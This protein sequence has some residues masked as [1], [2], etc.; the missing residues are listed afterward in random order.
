MKRI[1]LGICLAALL[2]LG[3]ADQTENSTRGP[4]QLT[5][6]QVFLPIT[7]FTVVYD[8]PSCP[9]GYDALLDNL[10]SGA[11]G[12]LVTLCYETGDIGKHPIDDITFTVDDEACPQ[13][14]ETVREFNSVEPADLNYG[15]FKKW[16]FGWFTTTKSVRMCYRRSGGETSNPIYHL[17]ILNK[18][19]PP[20]LYDVRPQ[21]LNS[22]LGEETLYV[23][24]SR[25]SSMLAA[26]ISLAGK[27]NEP[28][29][30]LAWSSA[31]ED[32][33]T[34]VIT[35]YLSF[36]CETNGEDFDFGLEMCSIA[37]FPYV[38]NE[39]QSNRLCALAMT[40][41]REYWSGN[42]TVK[43]VT[44]YIEVNATATN[45]APNKD[46]NI[47]ATTDPCGY[48]L[49]INA[50][51]DFGILNSE[52]TLFYQAGVFQDTEVHIDDESGEEAIENFK[53]VAAHEI[54]HS[55]LTKYKGL[56]YSASHKGTSSPSPLELFCES[57]VYELPECPEAPEPVDIM[58]YYNDTYT[59][60][61]DPGES[62]CQNGVCCD[63]ARI[64]VANED[65]AKLIMTAGQY[66]VT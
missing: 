11:N 42:L 45:V 40:G 33:D 10:N 29:D 64:E 56:C 7:D 32:L 31:V 61:C 47:C 17:R 55:F 6:N 62:I 38:L 59:L 13:E 46:I 23:A 3:L 37:K 35:V 53:F 48:N 52:M 54:G 14:W 20:R 43:G 2:H 26:A 58:K 12:N 66:H 34:G 19:K 30:T 5:Q 60:V 65:R 21:D 15:T 16:F 63:L 24:F 57:Y 4:L 25:S 1:V 39:T 36:E 27:G 51:D 8:S 50:D 9:S 41:I 49:A 22:G 44:R 18:R 28:R